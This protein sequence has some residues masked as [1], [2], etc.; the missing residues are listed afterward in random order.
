MIRNVIFIVSL[1]IINHLYGEDTIPIS[2][3]NIRI[4]KELRISEN[5]RLAPIITLR[6][7]NNENNTPL[8]GV[9]KIITAKDS[10]H[11]MQYKNGLEEN[12]YPTF[13]TYYKNDKLIAIDLRGTRI[14]GYYYIS[15][16]NFECLSNHYMKAFKKDYDTNEIKQEFVIFQKINKKRIKWKMYYGHN[17]K[18]KLVYPREFFEKFNICKKCRIK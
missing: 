4:D 17:E 8:N 7:I 2:I 13:T 3:N 16:P 1:F 12:E 15:I 6:K 10:Y 18:S 11:F 14:Y 9:Y 5:P